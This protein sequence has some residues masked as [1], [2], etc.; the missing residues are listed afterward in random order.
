MK[1]SAFSDA[2]K[3]FI[4]KQGAEGWAVLATRRTALSK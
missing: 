4:A 3:G 1:A 2:E